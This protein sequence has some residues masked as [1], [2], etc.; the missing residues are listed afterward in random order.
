MQN[1]TLEQAKSQ[2]SLLAREINCPADVAAKFTMMKNTP[3]REEY[4]KVLAILASDLGM[5]Y[6]SFEKKFMIHYEINEQTREVTIPKINVSGFIGERSIEKKKGYRYLKMFY[7][8]TPSDAL[9][10]YDRLNN[11][12][13]A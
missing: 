6:D 4:F 3:H 11:Q 9:S 2:Y 7:S 8:K 1:L 13:Y 10:E 12:K 5:V